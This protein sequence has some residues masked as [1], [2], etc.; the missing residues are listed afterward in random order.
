MKDGWEAVVLRSFERVKDRLNAAWRAEADGS[1]P[2]ERM[3]MKAAIQRLRPEIFVIIL[4]LDRT[5]VPGAADDVRSVLIYDFSRQ[6]PACVRFLGKAETDTSV[7]RHVLVEQLGSRYGEQVLR[8]L[9]GDPRVTGRFD[10]EDTQKTVQVLLY[11][12]RRNQDRL[13]SDIYLHLS[14]WLDWTVERPDPLAEYGK[15]YGLTPE[16]VPSEEALMRPDPRTSSFGRWREDGIHPLTLRDLAEAISKM[17]LI[18]AV[19][20][21]VRTTLQRAKDLYVQAYF[22]YDFF[23]IATL[24]AWMA[25]EAALRHRWCQ[26]L[27][28]PIRL[29]LTPGKRGKK[30]RITL[31]L[32]RAEYRRMEE[33]C[34]DS[35]RSPRELRVNGRPFP[36]SMRDLLDCLVNEGV[37]TRWEQ[38][39]CETAWHLR[40]SLAHPE[41]PPVYLPSNA[42]VAIRTAAEMINSLFDRPRAKEAVPGP[43]PETGK[44]AE[45]P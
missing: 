26:T 20:D 32:D 17:V 37:L 16:E 3:A 38:K 45:F 21:E 31:R 25:L 10:T 34:F 15:R 39:L 9:D 28:L 11:D 36:S 18:P 44:A 30:P 27:R 14:S 29:E 7:F 22:K 19:P 1:G 40:N 8:D 2:P 24:L 23:T 13:E 41:Q 42:L 12:V 4:P 33:F 43:Q 5:K 35:H 6:G